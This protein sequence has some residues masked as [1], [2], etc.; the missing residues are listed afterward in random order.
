MVGH[1]AEELIRTMIIMPPLLAVD[2]V[3]ACCQGEGDEGSRRPVVTVATYPL[4][5][6]AGPL[7]RM[8]MV[9]LIIMEEEEEEAVVV[10]VL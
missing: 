6:L 2:R 10:G 4:R 7:Q 5:I 8:P 3:G 9:V 1:I